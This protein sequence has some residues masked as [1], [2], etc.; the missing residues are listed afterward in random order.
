MLT[1]STG[2]FTQNSL[3]DRIKRFYS[4]THEKLRKPWAPF[5]YGDKAG[6]IQ[7]LSIGARLPITFFSDIQ[8]S[9]H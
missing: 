4:K 8:E 3:G 1:F 7:R 2:R 6:F 9:A 5:K